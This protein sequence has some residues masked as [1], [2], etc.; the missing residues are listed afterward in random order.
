MTHED[1]ASDFA[2]A[3]VEGMDMDTLVTFAID[4]LRERYE[5]MSPEDLK[6]EV[7]EYHPELLET[8]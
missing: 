2:E 1:L 5:A 7:E 4:T 3:I 6:S 8:E